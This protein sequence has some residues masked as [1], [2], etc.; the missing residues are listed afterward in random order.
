MK[1]REG[2]T[3]LELILVIVIIGV[4]STVAI[5]KFGN[6]IDNSKISSELSTASSVQSAIDATHGE[7]IVNSCEFRWGNDQNSS[8]LNTNGYPDADDMGESAN[9]FKNLLKNSDNGDWLRND[10]YTPSRYYGPATN[11]KTKNRN[12]PHKPEGDDYWE[13]NSTAGTFKLIEP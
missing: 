1:L 10:S 12:I 5:P 8:L 13:Y 4:L 9:P 7:W 6:L 3:L 2:F 11:H